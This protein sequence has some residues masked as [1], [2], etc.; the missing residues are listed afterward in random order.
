MSVA[1]STQPT[2]VLGEL[3]LHRLLVAIDGSANAELALKAAVTAARRDNATITLITVG[4]D[5]TTG[6][7]AW[8]IPV[9]GT[10]D[11]RSQRVARRQVAGLDDD[12]GAG[13]I[14]SQLAQ[15]N[16]DR[17]AGTADAHHAPVTEQ[18]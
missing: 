2:T 11:Q 9:A 16:G 14:V 18:G 1:D 4:P 12:D 15:W 5:L 6:P 13:R 3:S 17:L 10:L 7:A 8:S